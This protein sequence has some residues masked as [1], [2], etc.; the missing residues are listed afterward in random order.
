MVMELLMVMGLMVLAAGSWC[1]LPL[2][3]MLA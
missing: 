1:M 2:L 3:L